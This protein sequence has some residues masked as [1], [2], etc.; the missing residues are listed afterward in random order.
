MG[1]KVFLPPS[2][3]PHTANWPLR[4]YFSQSFKY[5]LHPLNIPVIIH[6]ALLMRLLVYSVTVKCYVYHH[7]HS[8]LIVCS[9]I[10]LCSVWLC[11]VVCWGYH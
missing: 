4:L 1:Q 3:R 8:G 7:M 10:L 6:R 2:F 9:I 5:V 11:A